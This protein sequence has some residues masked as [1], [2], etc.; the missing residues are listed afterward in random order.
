M[1]SNSSLERFSVLTLLLWSLLPVVVAQAEP[2]LV[3]V[4]DRRADPRFGL[5]RPTIAYT[6]DGKR[7]V[8]KKNSASEIGLE[9][10]SLRDRNGVL[11]S[12]L[13]VAFGLPCIANSEARWK[14]EGCWIKGTVSPWMEG[15]LTLMDFPASSISNPEEAVALLI[16]REF[17]GDADINGSNFLV[18]I[19][20]G[21][22]YAIDLDKAFQGVFIQK[23]VGFEEIMDLHASPERV[24]PV[25]ERIKALERE[26][27]REVLERIGSEVLEDWSEESREEIL[28]NLLVNREALLRGDPYS[29]YYGKRQVPW[30]FPEHIRISEGDARVRDDG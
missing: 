15:A 24:T 25:L 21:R 17:L 13:M 26:E 10:A 22:L 1:N 3:Q 20:S 28:S 19:E 8:A 18:Q 9:E 7:V 5:N 16:W 29:R 12:H 4:T 6:L 2:C 14:M 23:S 27:L 11:A 30:F